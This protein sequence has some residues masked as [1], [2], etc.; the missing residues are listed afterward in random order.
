MNP[1]ARTERARS[2]LR[3]HPGVSRLF[4]S[5]TLGIFRAGAR[6]TGRTWSTVGRGGLLQRLHAVCMNSPFRA[7]E[8]AWR[9]CSSLDLIGSASV[10]FPFPFGLLLFFSSSSFPEI[11]WMSLWVWCLCCGIGEA[12]VGIPRA[13][14]NSIR[15]EFSRRR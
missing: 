5:G 2:P 10:A 4:W 15:D 9:K 13:P 1:R 8:I 11:W 6:W 14:C 7:C 3:G 12:S